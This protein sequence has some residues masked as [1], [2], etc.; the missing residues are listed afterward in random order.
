M[1]MTID[2]PTTKSVTFNRYWLDAD[3]HLLSEQATLE[4]I[5]YYYADDGALVCEC[6]S[7]GTLA[8]VA[9]GGDSYARD[10]RGIAR[11]VWQGLP[12][13]AYSL[14]WDTVGL[15]LTD[16]WRQGA[17]SCGISEDE[18]TLEERLQRD[19]LINDQRGY[20]M[21]FLDWVREHRRDGPAKLPLATI[22]A[23]ANTWGNAWNRAYNEAAARAC[24]DQKLRW[25]RHGRRV[26]KVSCEDCINLDGRIY[27]ASVWTRYSIFPQ[28]PD[29]ACHGVNCGC[30]FQVAG[31]DEKCTPGR[32]PRIAGQR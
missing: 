6:G 9:G 3:G 17:E 7:L 19:M 11:A 4:P 24:G 2:I 20:I 26:T 25:V 23:R 10:I 15:G 16:A 5:R 31:P 1:P 21:G 8:E 32:P 12:L 29:L 18:L 13:D 14:M 27:R 22:I 30:A 28:S